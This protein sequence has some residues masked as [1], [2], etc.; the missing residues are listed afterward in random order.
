MRKVVST[1]DAVAYG[2][3]LIGALNSVMAS[4]HA[5]P[6]A[7]K[8]NRKDI[9]NG[10]YAGLIGAA[11][12]YKLIRSFAFKT[13]EEKRL[14]QIAQYVD[15]A[16]GYRRRARLYYRAADLFLR[17]RLSSLKSATSS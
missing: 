7:K 3:V 16:E 12:L 9:M 8:D 10:T 14:E 1:I 6:N 11:G 17:R 5:E 4:M 13:R 2:V 15:T